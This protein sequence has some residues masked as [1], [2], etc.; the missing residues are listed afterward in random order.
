MYRYNKQIGDTLYKI[1]IW[2]TA[3]Q[4]QYRNLHPSYFF[5]ADGCIMVFDLT[6]KTTYQNLSDWYQQ[7]RK[8]AGDIPVILVANKL[9]L[10]LESASKKFKFAEQNNIPMYF[11][12]SATGVNVVRVFEE[13]INQS[14]SYNKSGKKNLVKEILG[15]INQENI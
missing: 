6:R 13:I 1:D 8:H 7:L 3:G 10:S 15:F 4:D 14:I 12:S 9:D 11:T 2:D 5:D